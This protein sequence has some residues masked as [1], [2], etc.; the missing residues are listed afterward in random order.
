MSK[1]DKALAMGC[2]V[3]GLIWVALVWLTWPITKFFCW[4]MW[5]RS[6]WP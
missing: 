3:L 6:C 2:F 4:C 1:E 5:H